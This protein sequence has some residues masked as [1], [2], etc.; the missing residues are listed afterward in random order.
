VR[1]L[2]SAATILQVLES[3]LRGTGLAN[4]NLVVSLFMCPEWGGGRSNRCLPPIFMVGLGAIR[5]ESWIALLLVNGSGTEVE[6]SWVDSSIC[7][8]CRKRP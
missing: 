2:P 6:A 4:R 7:I 8:A 5:C 1:R 3:A